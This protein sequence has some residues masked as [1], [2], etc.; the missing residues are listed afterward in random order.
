[1]TAATMPSIRL[2]PPNHEVILSAHIRFDLPTG[3]FPPGLLVV[4]SSKVSSNIIK[5]KIRE[6]QACRFYRKERCLRNQ[7]GKKSFISRSVLNNQSISQIYLYSSISKK[8][9]QKLLQFKLITFTE[10]LIIFAGKHRYV[11]L[12]FE[13][14]KNVMKDLFPLCILGVAA[15]FRG[16]PE[17]CR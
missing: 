2:R 4:R 13:F 8:N 11:F 1:M 12:K 17:F 3:L 10:Y 15:K 14:F 9:N 5:K 7:T 16:L 6:C